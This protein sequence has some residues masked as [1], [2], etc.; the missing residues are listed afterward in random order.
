MRATRE[1]APRR[2]ESVETSLG[3]VRVKVWGADGR[4]RLRPEHDDVAAIAER[5]GLPYDEVRRR[6]TSEAEAALGW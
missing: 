2:A 6:V 4:E 5:E 3:T 1:V